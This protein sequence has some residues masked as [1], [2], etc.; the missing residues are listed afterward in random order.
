MKSSF[1]LG[2]LFVAAAAAA[3][4]ETEMCPRIKLNFDVNIVAKGKD[5]WAWRCP[6]EECRPKKNLRI[7]TT[8]SQRLIHVQS[9]ASTRTARGTFHDPSLLLDR[10]LAN[11]C[12]FSS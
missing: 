9:L 3:P 11:A 10:V 12:P 7:R 6:E 8:S 4:K 2:L 1:L 5:V